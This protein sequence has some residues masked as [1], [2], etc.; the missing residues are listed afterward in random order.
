MLPCTEAASLQQKP[1]PLQA[2]CHTGPLHDSSFN[3]SA[4]PDG[5]QCPHHGQHQLGD[6]RLKMSVANQPRTGWGNPQRN[7]KNK[8]TNKQKYNNNKKKKQPK[9]KKNQKEKKRRRRRRKPNRTVSWNLSNLSMTI[10]SRLFCFPQFPQFKLNPAKN[11]ELRTEAEG[12]KTVPTTQRAA[13]SVQPLTAF[14][15]CSII[16]AMLFRPCFWPHF[17]THLLSILNLPPSS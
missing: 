11:R 13:K 7:I 8:Q 12:C 4:G 6:P 5:S 16:P 2:L 1:C 10:R 14:A 17:S 15:P 3:W 9:K